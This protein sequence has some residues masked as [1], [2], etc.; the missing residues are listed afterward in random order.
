MNS[1]DDDEK[2]N[3]Q[4]FEKLSRSNKSLKPLNLNLN[5]TDFKSN[6]I[7]TEERSDNKI[8]IKIP[9][10]AKFRIRKKFEFGNFKKFVKRA[11]YL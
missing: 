1:Y 6:T 7:V 11:E 8:K 10:L 2:K 3:F 4:F 9:K 5:F